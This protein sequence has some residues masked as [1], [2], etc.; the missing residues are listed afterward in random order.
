MSKS[1]KPTCVHCGTRARDVIRPGDDHEPIWV[2]AQHAKEA[3]S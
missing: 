2:C 3:R 1:E